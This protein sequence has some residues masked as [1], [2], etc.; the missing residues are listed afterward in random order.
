VRVSILACVLSAVAAI[1]IYAGIAHL[2]AARHPWFRTVHLT[3]AAVAALAAVH[4]LAHIAVYASQDVGAYLAASRYSNLSGAITMA[5]L[6]WLVRG[7]F[8]GGPRIV[9]SLLSAFFLLSGGLIEFAPLG[10]SIRPMP[11][12]EQ[13]VLPWAERATIHRASATPLAHVLFWTMTSFLLAYVAALAVRRHRRGNRRH[14]MAMVAAIAILVLAIGGNGL[15]FTNHLDSILMGEFGFLALVLIMMRLLSGE[16]SYRAI[17]AQASAGIFVASATGRLLQVNR[18]G[19]RMLANSRSELR[20]L[21]IADLM[22]GSP[23][24]ASLGGADGTH[25][26]THGVH[27]LRRKDGSTLVVDVST[28]VLSDG[29]VLYIAHDITETQRVNAAIQLLAESGPPDDSVQFF[30]R[31]AQSIAGA[32]DVHHAFIGAIDPQRELMLALGQWS[33]G[34]A[35]PVAYRLDAAPCSQLGSERRSIHTRDS[36]ARFAG[37]APFVGRSINGYLGA[38]IVSSAQEIIGVVEVWDE[39]PF[40]AGAES[41][42]LLEMFAHRIAAEIERT[43]SEGALRQ[44]AASLETRVAARTAELAQAN[45]E[46]EAFSYSVS[47]DLRAPVRAVDAHIRLLAEQ[48]G[49]SLDASARKHF[50]RIAQAAQRMRELIEGLLTLSRLSHQP[51]SFEAVDLSA[52]AQQTFE[53]LQER[54]PSRAVEFVCEQGVVA[55]ADRAAAS[56]VISNVIE[57]AWKYSSRAADARIHFGQERIEGEMVFFVRD[58]G[59][60]FDMKHAKHLFEPFQRLHDQSDFPGTGIGLATV[61]RIVKR[62]RGRI[63]AHSERGQGAAFYFT[64][65]RPRTESMAVNNM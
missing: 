49:D 46:L 61:E 33:L 18:A 31:C 27:R 43:A 55:R 3:F 56:I 50:D 15:V 8:G 51:L 42:K 38:A 4:A 28:Q 57:N 26:G 20:T 5:I 19:R 52:L 47:H 64:L 16:E 32:F 14:T 23:Q 30:T 39:R 12:L 13:I 7:Y 34:D 54:D 53:L 10:S 36:S 17:V 25:E 22:E 44:L 21:S 24:N 45:A 9:P 59:V 1:C 58:N 37:H 35:D 6:P 63:W 65:A 2:L 41:R 40:I 62:H 11:I 48:L 60:G 29:R